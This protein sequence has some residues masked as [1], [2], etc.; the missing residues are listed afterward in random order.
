[1]ATAE[2]IASTFPHRARRGRARRLALAL[3]VLAIA[4]LAWFRQPLRSYAVN[5]AAYGA[6]VG[7]SCRYI[8]GRPLASCRRDLERDLRFVRLS[9]DAEARSVTAS[10]PLLSSQTATFQE[11]PGCVLEKWGD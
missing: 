4:L 6:H 5:G 1:M 10:V 2:P 11:G 9:E 7:C 3:A 8:E